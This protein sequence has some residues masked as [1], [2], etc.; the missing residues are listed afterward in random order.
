M[1]FSFQ[2]FIQFH[3]KDFKKK[4]PYSAEAKYLVWGKLIKNLK[5]LQFSWFGNN[6][7][8]HRGKTSFICT[9]LMM[10]RKIHSVHDSRGKKQISILALLSILSNYRYAENFCEDF[11]N[12]IKE[13]A[14]Y[15]ICLKCIKGWQ[16][17]E[18]DRL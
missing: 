18:D 13:V 5:L 11:A 4:W 16:I 1:R 7:K 2:C 15:R 10:P 3:Y 9:S 6:L 14:C 17:S 12:L 8:P